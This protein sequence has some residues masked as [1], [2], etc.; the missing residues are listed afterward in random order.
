M[1]PETMKAVCFFNYG[2]PEELVIADLPVP[3]PD[4]DEILVKMCASSFSPADAKARNGWYRSMY[5]LTFPRIPSVE[6]GGEVVAMGKDVRQFHIGDKVI[7]FKDK[8]LGGAL[9]EYCAVKAED[10][11]LA[12]RNVELAPICAIPGYA[13]SAKQ[14]LTEEAHVTQGQRVMVIGAAG[15]IGQLAVQI[16]KSL[17]AYVIGC[18]VADCREETGKLGADEYVVAGSDEYKRFAQEKLDAVISVATLEEA[19]LKAYL[20]VMNRGGTFVS[21]VPLKNKVYAGPDYD[22]KRG[23]YSLPL[24]KEL[25]AETGV[26]CRWMT[27]QRGGDKLEK[28]VA[29]IE[30]GKLKPIINKTLTIYEYKQLNYDFEA[31]KV[32]GRNLVLI[33][34]HI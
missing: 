14:A 27:V 19:Q 12:P 18:D 16:A 23:L 17:G 2:S 32:R 5:E 9:A 7:A 4:N 3:T 24:S 28:I 11:C 25:E 30:Q 33:E 15:G 31:G 21:S 29:L 13:L 26:H 10:A 1:I 20:D 22:G 34:G 6:I 8:R